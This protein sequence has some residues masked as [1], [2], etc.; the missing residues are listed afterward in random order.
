MTDSATRGCQ[1]AKETAMVLACRRLL[2]LHS[3]LAILLVRSPLLRAQDL[4]EVATLKDDKPR[5]SRFAL[6]TPDGKSL[7]SGDSAGVVNLW[8]LETKK[9]NKRWVNKTID[10]RFDH[11]LNAALSPDGKSLVTTVNPLAGQDNSGAILFEHT[12]G[13]RLLRF[14]PKSGD[15]SGGSSPFVAAFS[16]DG[17]TL[18]TGN[19]RGYLILWDVT[20]GKEIA[21]LTEGGVAPAMHGSQVIETVCFSPD[22]K[23][24]AAAD[25]GGFRGNEF[26]PGAVSIWDVNKRKLITTWKGHKKAIICSAFVKDGKTL[27]TG[28][29]DG[30]VKLWETATGKEK[31]TLKVGV[32][33]NSIAVSPSGDRLAVGG[34]VDSG[35]NLYL[36]D[37]KTNEKSA[38][39]AHRFGVNSVAFSADGKMLVSAGGGFGSSAGDVKLWQVLST[40]D[41]DK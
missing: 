32:E 31:A 17:K 26:I 19:D 9:S 21:H 25:V 12:T 28:S 37:L 41:K 39:K 2:L 34:Y 29:R 27:A 36:F 35:D 16:P 38:S 1:S 14:G 3:V 4:R 20:T 13:K 22:G 10:D 33:V 8:D 11:V 24:L 30:T 18:V 15:G 40:K 23:T 7:I 6:F 5:M